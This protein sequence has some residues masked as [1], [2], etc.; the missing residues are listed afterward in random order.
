MA[1]PGG[2]EYTWQDL[3]Q[4]IEALQ[5]G[6]DIDYTGASGPIDLDDAGDATAGVYDLYEFGSD[7]AP[8]PT[9]EIEVT[10]PE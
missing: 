5:N 4:A 6:E 8:E 3:P 9:D 2:T 1:G 10:P 7:G